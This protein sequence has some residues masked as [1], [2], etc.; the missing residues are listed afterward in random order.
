MPVVINEFEV[1]ADPQQPKS[2]TDKEPA[3]PA[4]PPPPTPHDIACIVRHY[5][6]RL[7]RVR[8]Y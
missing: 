7:A 8:A 1:V 6:Q 5:K 2:T 3:V 4:P